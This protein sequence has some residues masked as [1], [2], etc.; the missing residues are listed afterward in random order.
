MRIKAAQ[1]ELDTGRMT[2]PAD[3][4]ERYGRMAKAA[5]THMK[6][7]E[8]GEPVNTTEGR[9]VGH[10]W[11]RDAD[12]APG[13]LGSEITQSH[14]AIAQFA[15]GAGSRFKQIL[16]I[17]IG[18]SGLGP[19]LLVDCLRTPATK[20]IHF[21]D[22]T[23]PEGFARVLGDIEQA[24]GLGETLTV[25]VSKSGGTKETR[26]G[27]LIAQRA[28]AQAGV[29]SF[30]EHAAAITQPGSELHL[31]AQGKPPRKPEPWQ[32]VFRGEWLASF[33]LWEWV[34]GRT[35]LFSA[36]G[37]LPAALLGFEGEKLL[38]GAADMDKATRRPQV[39][40][41]PALLLALAWYHAIEPLGLGSMVV[42]PYSDRLG[43]LGM[44]LQQLIMESLGKAG[45]GLAVY[46]NKGTTDQHSFV[47]QLRDG[48]RD[49]FVAFVRFLM[50][51]AA[52][53]EP[54]D[55]PGGEAASSDYLAALQDGTA[56]ALSAEGRPSLRITV[57]RVNA[58]TLGGL[59][60]LFER[61]V[62]FYAHMQGINAYDQPGVEAGKRAAGDYLKLQA[63]LIKRLTK[64]K[65]QY[66]SPLA[67]AEAAVAADPA[68][69]AATPELVDDILA[70]LTANKRYGLKSRSG[71]YG[72]E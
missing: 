66:A 59:I 65:G 20:P 50:G 27:M 39:E 9:Q 63:W 24:G 47:Q 60:A 62:G 5:V 12:S 32:S 11:L 18:G 4:T 2:L 34:G 53:D 15:T 10:Y 68:L 43:L 44:Y 69:A 57:D 30:E 51:G 6:A 13:K 52:C 22:N 17:G 55:D 41:N 37:L 46:G 23:D 25:V 71:E 19:R 67:L 7:L 33:P 35:S 14:S 61:A 64:K 28:Y 70:R 42:L 1:I 56:Q 26:N 48:K 21:F 38:K 58:Y 36:V 29:G 16:W 31:L 8:A 45:K 3:L 72:A 40:K 49:F 54:I